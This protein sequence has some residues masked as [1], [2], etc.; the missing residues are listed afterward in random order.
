MSCS[1]TDFS[2]SNNSAENVLEIIELGEELPS[3]EINNVTESPRLTYTSAFKEVMNMSAALVVTR[4]FLSLNNYGNSVILNTHDYN[5]SS[6][7]AAAGALINT[8]NGMAF[9]SLFAVT[10]SNYIKSIPMVIAK[11]YKEVRE[12]LLR[13][14]VIGVFILTPIAE[15]AFYY[16]E[17]LFANVMKSPVNASEIAAN[18]YKG[19]MPGLPFMFLANALQQ[20]MISVNRPWLM[21]FP[22]FSQGAVSITIG[23]LWALDS[24]LTAREA[25][26]HLG[27]AN[28]IAAFSIFTL[29]LFILRCCLNDPYEFFKARGEN[30]LNGVWE[31]LKVGSPVFVSGFTET[32]SM[33]ALAG[34]IGTLKND[35]LAQ[36]QIH[37]SILQASAIYVNFSTVFLFALSQ[38]CLALTRKIT[39]V[40]NDVIK[41]SIHDNLSQ[42]QLISHVSN[43]IGLTGAGLYAA[44]LCVFYSPATRWLLQNESLDDSTLKMVLYVYLIN[45]LFGQLIDSVRLI[46]NGSLIGHGDIVMPTII[47]IASLIGV[48]ISLGYLL[49][50]GPLSIGVLGPFAARQIG[51]S[52]G[53]L[54]SQTRLYF[55]R[56]NLALESEENKIEEIKAHSTEENNEPSALLTKD[57]VK[58]YT[59][60][61]FASSIQEN[62]EDSASRCGCTL[63]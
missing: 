2:E 59:P 35:D 56:K 60:S 29:N 14:A 21:V 6:D 16:S 7:A 55:V 3:L 24:N 18:F 52:I 20:S 5:N 43:F 42:M 61:F 4:V 26:L 36:R 48:G 15:V 47:N 62:E 23:S 33:F 58:N 53:A 34:F 40:P 28:S 31:L 39:A 8:F 46:G 25:A 54:S 30:L 37:L 57:K 51:I 9:T 22:A 11:N 50:P 12:N 38:S 17:S 44:C 19:Y 41:S 13:S 32:V 63:F 10:S 27:Y 1:K 45:N 49:G